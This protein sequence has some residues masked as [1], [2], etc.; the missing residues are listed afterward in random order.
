GITD[1]EIGPRLE[2]RLMGGDHGELTEPVESSNFFAV[3][4]HVRLGGESFDFAREANFELGGIEAFD[5]PDA[6]FTR[7][8]AIP[9]FGR[10]AAERRDYRSACDDDTPGHPAHF[11]SVQLFSWM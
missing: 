4:V 10:I 2:D 9:E 7:A 6:A 8:E 1:G 3:H 11:P 5:L